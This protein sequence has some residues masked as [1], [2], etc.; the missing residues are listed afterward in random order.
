MMHFSI[1]SFLYVFAFSMSSCCRELSRY[2]TKPNSLSHSSSHAISYDNGCVVSSIFSPWI[3]G[4]DC[5]ISEVSWSNALRFLPFFGWEFSF[6]SFFF[7]PLFD[8]EFPFFFFFLFLP[9]FDW[10]F[11]FF[12]FCFLPLFDWEFP[13]FFFFAFSL[14]G[15]FPSLP[16]CFRG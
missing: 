5:N 8:W 6:F 7:L 11:S 1:Y 10:E 16:F 9:F 12:S 14:I 15:N 13:F 2:T 4:K 3:N